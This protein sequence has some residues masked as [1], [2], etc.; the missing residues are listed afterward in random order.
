[1]TVRVLPLDSL[2]PLLGCFPVLCHHL[3]ITP[4]PTEHLLHFT[5]ISSS[6]LPSLSFCSFSALVASVQ[7]LSHVFAAWQSPLSFTT[8]WSLLKHMPIEP[9]MPS[10]HLILC[11]PLLLLP[12][13]F[14]SI[15][16]FSNESALHLRWPKYLSFIF[17]IS[18]FSAYLGLISFSVDWFDLFAVQVTLKSPSPA[19]QFESISSSV[20]S[21]LYDPAVISTHDYWKNHGSV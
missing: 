7:S 19:P 2:A 13:I 6:L 14:P 5:L 18:P 20:L 21:L 11:H 17:S 9:M 16:V 4:P 10:N 1:M 12:Y 3:V 15:T 8:S